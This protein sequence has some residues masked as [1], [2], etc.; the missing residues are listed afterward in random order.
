MFIIMATTGRFGNAPRGGSGGHT[1]E[2]Q[3]L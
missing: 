2:W 3:K 1:C